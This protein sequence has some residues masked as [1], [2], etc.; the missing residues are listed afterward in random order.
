M[1]YIQDDSIG[2]IG[3]VKYSRLTETQFQLLYGPGWILYAGQD[4]T[5]SQLATQLGITTLEDFRALFPRAGNNGRSDSFANPDGD[6]VA[7]TVNLDKFA[8][9]NHS[10]F[11]DESFGSFSSPNCATGLNN[12]GNVP[13]QFTGQNETAGKSGILNCFIRIN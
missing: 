11:S 2:T 3:E 9:H 4:I 5:G 12:H 1:P 6:Q 13:T 10:I 8:S 7:G